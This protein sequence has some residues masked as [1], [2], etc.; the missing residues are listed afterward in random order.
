LHD[1]DLINEATQPS[2]THED[3]LFASWSSVFT[4]HARFVP[5]DEDL[6]STAGRYFVD[7]GTLYPTGYGRKATPFAHWI[8]KVIAAFIVE[9][10][11]VKGFELSGI[12]ERQRYGSVEG[13][14][15]VWFPKSVTWWT[16]GS[17]LA[18]EQEQAIHK[19]GFV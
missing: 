17:G 12:G 13:N 18:H 1:F 14:S 4:T 9:D 15:D 6:T 5:V 7:F 19:L 11:Q 3:A 2:M 10:G 16:L 8:F